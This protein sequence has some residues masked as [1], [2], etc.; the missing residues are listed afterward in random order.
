MEASS[1]GLIPLKGIK[2]GDVNDIG[3]GKPVGAGPKRAPDTG[4]PRAP[5]R[6][7]I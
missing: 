7:S 2:H 5:E 3:K 6:R 4:L 1:V